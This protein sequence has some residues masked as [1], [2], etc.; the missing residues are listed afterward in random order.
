VNGHK[1]VQATV[2]RWIRA[3]LIH[4]IE[5][6]VTPNPCVW[7]RPFDKGPR[8]LQLLIWEFLWPWPG[9]TRHLRKRSFAR[10]SPSLSEPLPQ[11]SWNRILW[12]PCCGDGTAATH[13]GDHDKCAGRIAKSAPVRVEV[14]SSR[15]QG[16]QR[17]T[18]KADG[19]RRGPLSGRPSSRRRARGCPEGGANV[20]KAAVRRANVGRKAE[21]TD[22][23]RSPRCGLCVLKALRAGPSSARG[24]CQ[25]L[26]LRRRA[27]Y[28]RWTN[29][30]RKVEP[31]DHFRPPRWRS[32]GYEEFRDD[33]AATAIRCDWGQTL[34]PAR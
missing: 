9:V 29:G 25:T 28:R 15:T 10:I 14:V 17:P 18:T 33:A 6:S 3:E 23:F 32:I 7:K 1:P 12:Q 22:Q 30:G 13:V 24:S 4:E 27:E 19:R 5:L 2:A 20:E 21:P 8:P 16:G 11:P 31:T 26:S 34:A